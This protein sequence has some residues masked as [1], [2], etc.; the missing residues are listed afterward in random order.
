MLFYYAKKQVQNVCAIF[1]LH[2]S[3]KIVMQSTETTKLFVL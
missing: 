2:L 1:I 3:I